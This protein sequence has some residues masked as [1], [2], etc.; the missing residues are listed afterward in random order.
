MNAAALLALQEID[1]ELDTIANRRPRLPEVAVHAAATAALTELLQRKAAVQRRIDM[2]QVAIEAAEA[3]SHSLTTKRARLETQLKTIISPREAEALMNQ[4]AGLNTHRDE[5][6]DQELAALEEQAVAEVELA[7]I[8][9]REPE[10]HQALAS[11][12]AALAEVNGVLDA[13]V[14]ALGARRAEAESVLSPAELTAYVEARHHGGGVG[15]AKLDGSR[16][17]GCHLDLSPMEMDVVK[18][19]AAGEQAEC[20]QCGRFLVR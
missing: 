16:C 6:D 1:T 14:L 13:E 5:L 10:L 11:A 4:I 18:G 8:E 12:R 20:P 7:A 9:D 19:I 2:A 15:V 3:E 17:G